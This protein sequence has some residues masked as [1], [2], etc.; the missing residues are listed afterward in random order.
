M[1]SGDPVVVEEWFWMRHSNPK[2]VWTRIPVAP[3]VAYAIYRRSWRLLLLS[4]LWGVVNPILFSPPKDEEAWMTRGVLAQQWWVRG[5]GHG[6]LGVSKPNIFSTAAVLTSIYTLYA[7]WRQRPLKTALGT[8]LTVVLNFWWLRH[9]VERYD[10][11]V[12]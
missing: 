3:A 5:E 11:H 8:I 4:I 2:S 10:R 12:T 7:A 6:I 1:A 9:L